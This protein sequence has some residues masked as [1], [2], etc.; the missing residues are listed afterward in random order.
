MPYNR[1]RIQK[2]CRIAIVILTAIIVAIIIALIMLNL[3]FTPDFRAVIDDIAVLNG[4]DKRLVYAVIMAESGFDS[5]AVSPK[6]AVGLMQLMP[7]TAS[8]VTG[9]KVNASKLEN[10]V[11]NI[12]IGTKLLSNYIA[13]YGD[14]R[15]VLCAYNAGAGVLERWLK[16]GVDLDNPPYKETKNYV[17]KVMAFYRGYSIFA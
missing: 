11:I 9:F 1:E 2:N 7:D 3:L 4:V 6:G 16:D 5:K 14:I 15:A 8:W 13:K 17:R 10:P 12:S